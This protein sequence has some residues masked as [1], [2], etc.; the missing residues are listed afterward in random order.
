MKCGEGERFVPVLKHRIFRWF[1]NSGLVRA[2]TAG[3]K[4]MAS[5]SGCAM[6]RQIRLFCSR[7]KDRMNGEEL[8]DERVQ[9]RKTA[10]MPTAI[11][12]QLK[13]GAMSACGVKRR[14]IE[15]VDSRERWSLLCRCSQL[16]VKARDVVTILRPGEGNA[17]VY[18]RGGSWSCG[19]RPAKSQEL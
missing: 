15:L 5:S 9:K 7:G 17:T 4:N 3:A 6:S 8:V 12:G 16:R 2:N 19:S 11:A 14:R 18:G 10:A 1:P 13:E